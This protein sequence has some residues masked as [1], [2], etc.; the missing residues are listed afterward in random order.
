[1]P[2]AYGYCEVVCLR[3]SPVVLRALRNS[4]ARIAE[5]TVGYSIAS[6][7]T[8][9]EAASRLIDHPEKIWDLLKE[10]LEN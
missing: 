9:P 8:N 5:N 1:M 2:N 10:F 3:L 4:A 6:A 7:S